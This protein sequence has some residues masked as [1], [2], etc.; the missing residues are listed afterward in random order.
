[1]DTRILITAKKTPTPILKPKGARLLQRYYLD[2]IQPE[3]ASLVNEQQLG[4]PEQANLTSPPFAPSPRGHN[5]GRMAVWPGASP[6]IQ[7]KLAIGQPNNNTGRGNPLPD[8]VHSFMEPRQ[9]ANFSQVRVHTDPQAIQ[10]AAYT[11]GQNVVL[12]AG[13]YQPTTDAGR[14][15]SATPQGLMLQRQPKGKPATPQVVTPQMVK[16]QIKAIGRQEI[17]EIL[18]ALPVQIWDGKPHKIKQITIDEVEHL[19]ELAITLKP[20]SPLGSSAAVTGELD[21]VDSS[22]KPGKKTVKHRILISLSQTMPNPVETVFHELIHAR[23]IMDRDLPEGEQS[24]IFKQFAQMK[25]I[26]TDPA[27]LI[28]TKTGPKRDAVI[29]NIQRVHAFFTTFAGFN[30]PT[31]PA[32]LSTETNYEFLINEKFTNQ[33]AATAF[34]NTISNAT[35]ARR[36]ANSIAEKF[37]RAAQSHN[38]TQLQAALTNQLDKL[39]DAIAQLAK[40]T[41]ELFKALDEQRDIIEQAKQ[42]TDKPG[43]GSFSGKVLSGPALAP[44]PLGLD[45]K[46]VPI[47]P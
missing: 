18:D 26:A 2:Q 6:S 8:D 13:Q 11:V 14:S 16:S 43:T 47:K 21:P 36:Y 15:L 9:G 44:A 25:A 7:P 46:P 40:A 27:L 41:E 17:N 22:G 3:T 35:I 10:A 24:T 32:E 12:G 4:T 39:D 34:K 45:G 5:F 23:I 29:K 31:L 19:W 28:V 30:P 42:S 38:M 20:S 1:M 37:Q 33:T